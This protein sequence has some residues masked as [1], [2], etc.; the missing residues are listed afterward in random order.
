MKEMKR[1]SQGTMS[2]GPQVIK[3]ERGEM[4]MRRKGKHFLPDTRASYKKEEL[5][6]SERHGKR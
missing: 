3:R 1:T 2:S 4:L 5:R 6:R